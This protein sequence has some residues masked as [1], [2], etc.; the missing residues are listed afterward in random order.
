MLTLFRLL[1][2]KTPRCTHC[3][4]QDYYPD[5][6]Q[7]RP[8][9]VFLRLARYSC[10]GCRAAFWLPARLHAE[11][12]LQVVGGDAP[13]VPAAEQERQWPDPDAMD[14]ALASAAPAEA[15]ARPETATAGDAASLAALDAAAAP[16]RPEARDLRALDAEVARARKDGPGRQRRRSRNGEE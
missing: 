7:L 13:V 14:A 5:P 2:M 4:S 8:L 3:G 16:A 15:P 1:R 10:R 9:L 6:G 12:H 11:P